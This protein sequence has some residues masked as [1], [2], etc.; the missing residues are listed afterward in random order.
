MAQQGSPYLQEVT[1]K[2]SCSTGLLLGDE[3]A[4]GDLSVNQTVPEIYMDFC[5]SH[6]FDD[7]TTDILKSS[8][9]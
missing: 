9:C 5:N 1:I 3:G 6:F 8:K 4:T 2:T 7:K